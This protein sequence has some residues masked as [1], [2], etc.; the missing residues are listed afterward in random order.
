M[1]HARAYGI[2]ALAALAAVAVGVAAAAFAQTT[3]TPL[4]DNAPVQAAPLDASAVADLAKAHW[5]DAKAGATK[6]GACAACHGLDGN[7]SDPQYP[8]LA[9]MPERYVA[10]QLALF[11][12][13][14]RNTGMAAVMMPMAAPLSAQDMRDLGA[15][16]ATQKSG[17]G[18]AD[19]SAITAGPYAGMKFY[20]VGEKLFHGGDASRGIP[21]CMACHGPSGAGNP[22]PAYPHVGGQQ[23]AYVV[24]RLQEFRAGTTP[25]RDPHLFNVMATVAKSLT[26][27]EIQSLASYLQGLHD[28]GGEAAG[29]VAAA[30][31]AT[32]AP[33]PAPTTPVPQS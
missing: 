25:E 19:D 26:D 12:G 17:A 3:V 30:G 21:A 29:A 31:A 4:P 28:R 5:G 9:G 16:F 24:R 2:A 32:P 23:S 6:A 18:I 14:E 15:Y 20:E 11:K 13:G 27:E 22:G 1:R 7:P 8:R 33:Q 10:Q